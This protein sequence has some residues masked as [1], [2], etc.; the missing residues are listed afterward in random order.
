MDFRG[1]GEGNHKNRADPDRNGQN[2]IQYAQVSGVRADL[3][4]S[5][6]L[7]RLAPNEA[8][9]ASAL[10]DAHRFQLWSA[11]LGPGFWM[12]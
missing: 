4:I 1:S 11:Q 10:P 2:Y 3:G 9:Q 8:T 12:P 5:E 6:F 7:V